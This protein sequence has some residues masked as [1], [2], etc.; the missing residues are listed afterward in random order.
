[1]TAVATARTPSSAQR[2]SPTLRRSRHFKRRLVALLYVAPALAVYSVV[3]L[4]PTGQSV[5]ISFFTW[6]GINAARWTGLDNYADFLSNE[7]LRDAVLHTLVLMLFY[8]LLPIALGLLSAA[9][10]SRGRHRGYGVFRSIIF[11]PQVMTSVV[12]AVVWRRIYAPDGPLNDALRAVGLDALAKNWLGDFTW[13][14]PSLGLV[15]T[16]ATFGLCM[17]LF[18][19][20]AQAIPTELYDAARV[21]GAGAVRE[22]F[23]VTL[24]A[25]RGQLAVALT[26]TVIG[27][28][29]AFDLI[30]LTT[31]GGPG[32]ATTTPAIELYEGAF[33]QQNVGAA[34]A[35][36]VVLA[37]VSML[38]ALIII[39]IAEGAS[40]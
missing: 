9:L 22:F 16:W 14:L 12:I 33:V 31:R 37:I 26:I 6:D 17:V 40:R 10:L 19:A 20:G 35:I 34:A 25:L 39:R 27:A 30:W 3:V 11:L 18:V 2:T 4:V 23:A 8:A 21:D 1:M 7:E 29:R 5:Y 15:G 38:V 36:G 24:P 28:L 32:T 13:A